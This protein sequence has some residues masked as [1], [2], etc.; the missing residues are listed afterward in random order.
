MFQKLQSFWKKIWST[1]RQAYKQTFKHLQPERTQDYGDTHKFNFLAVFVSKLNNLVNTE[2]TFELESD[3]VLTEPLRELTE[4]LESSRFDF[5]AE[6]L[7]YGDV[8]VFPATDSD[9]KLYH[10]YVRGGDVCIIDI[11]GEKVTDVLGIIDE[12]A[13]EKSGK[14][15]LLNRRHTL[16]DGVLT[17]ETYVT[18]D[19][20]R[21][22]RFD[23]W[24]DSESVYTFTG[25]N[26]IGVGRFKSPASSRGKSPVYGVPLNFGCGET[27][28]RCFKD[29]ELIETEFERAESKIFADPLILRKEKFG[30]EGYKIP[31]GIFPVTG[32]KLGDSRGGIEI[33]SPEI[34]YSAYY[35]KLVND[36]S[37]YEQA[38]GTDRGFLTPFESVNA[39]TAT[40]IRRA[41]ASTVALLD[42][43]R[44]AIKSGIDSVLKADALF[45]GV[46]EDLYAVKIDWFD[47]FADEEAQYNRLKGAV[48]R[49]IAE[50]TDELKWLFPNLSLE[51]REAKLARIKSSKNIDE[52][53]ALEK[54]LRG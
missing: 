43:I 37:Q 20:N 39:A 12:Y 25:A 7:A 8:W 49:G 52:D 48:D 10:R 41:N 47:V 54:I 36:L 23:L 44:N 32:R 24:A 21:R 5:T 31:E 35:S 26:G 34:R 16:S 29:L 28:R 45:L 38:V 50:K 40:E 27:E 46:P 3:S 13:D 19:N 15:F 18:D 30:D 9:G 22:C 11:D 17:V 51:E 14:T 42:K 6:M 53:E 2:A 1:Y 33:F 4:N